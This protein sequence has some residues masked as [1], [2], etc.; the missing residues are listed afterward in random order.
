MLVYIREAHPDSVLFTIRDGAETLLKITQTESAEKRAENAQMCSATLKLNVPTVLD[1][2]DN[3][4]N[5][6]YAG[7]PDR[8]YVVGV[9]GRIAYQGGQGPSGFK[10]GEVEEWLKQ[11]T[12]PKSAVP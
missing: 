11:N 1:G 10:V 8:L 7:W 3:R 12:K 9:D 5:I 2:D 4:V 6:A